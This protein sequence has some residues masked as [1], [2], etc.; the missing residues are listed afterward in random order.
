M[1]HFIFRSLP[2]HGASLG[3]RRNWLSF[4]DARNWARAQGLRNQFEWNTL[5]PRRH[6]NVPSCPRSTYKCEFQGMRDFLGYVVR[7][8]TKPIS[9]SKTAHFL[10]RQEIHARGVEM[11]EN[12]LKQ[13]AVGFRVFRM[14][15]TCGVDLMIQSESQSGDSLWAGVC[16]R[17]SHPSAP[18][19]KG[20]C[21]RRSQRSFKGTHKSSA[22]VSDGL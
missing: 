9:S 22:S 5:G 2:R 7:H 19:M 10:R 14:P 4:E 21:F 11:V 18:G 8:S 12:I 6:P 20:C 17:T 3:K 15:H 13:S 16:V 1:M